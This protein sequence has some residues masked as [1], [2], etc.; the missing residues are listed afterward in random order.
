MKIVS[1]TSTWGAGFFSYCVVLL[2]DIIGV[3]NHYGCYPERIITKSGFDLYKRFPEDDV[4]NT[5]FELASPDERD[6]N[7]KKPPKSK[8]SYYQRA[9]GHINISHPQIAFQ[10]WEQY[11]D[12]SKFNFDALNPVVKKYFIPTKIVL[13]IKRAM[14]AQY[15]IEPDNCLG[16]Y[17]RGTDKKSE[18]V[19]CGY[20]RFYDKIKE[21]LQPGQ[22]LLVQTDSA[23]S[24]EYLK[25]KN[26]EYICIK[27][28]DVSHTDKGIHNEKTPA[29]NHEDMK[30]LLATVL[31]LAECKTIINSVSNVS[32]WSVLLRGHGRG[33]Y[34]WVGGHPKTAIDKIKK[35]NYW[36]A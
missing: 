9:R 29:Q 30:Y 16:V 12:Y 24:L 15:G 13:D 21:V 11:S 6:Y 23:Q 28:N 1:L 3:L 17:Y 20:E 5:F 18:V 36:T 22:Q 25:E 31:I 2:V 14:M 26:V 19:E 33:I 10:Y 32:M 27:Q 34:Q 7:K 8:F 4:F 35:I